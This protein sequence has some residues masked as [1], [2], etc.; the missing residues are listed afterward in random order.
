LYEFNTEPVAP[1]FVETLVVKVPMPVFENAAIVSF[2]DLR[3]FIVVWSDEISL[4][5]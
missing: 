4:F 3:F 5:R 2:S 1:Y